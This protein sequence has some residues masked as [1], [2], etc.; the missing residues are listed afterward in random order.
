MRWRQWRFIVLAGVLAICGLT[1]HWWREVWLEHSQ[2]TPIR[3]A[4]RRYGLEPALVKAVVWRESHFNP[5]ARGRAHELGLMQLQED[6]AL[7]WAASEHIPGFEHQQCLDPMTN[8][9]AGTWYLTKLLH[10]YQRTDNPL[11]YALAD[12]NAGRGNVL[13]W[14]S[15]E[16]MTN[17]AAFLSQIGFPGTKAYVESILQRYQRYRPVFLAD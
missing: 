3:V 1:G 10:R 9:L 15:G 4:A 11:A 12:Y 17:S 2:D 16:A 5:A 6:A 13:K 8:A 14:N 7:E